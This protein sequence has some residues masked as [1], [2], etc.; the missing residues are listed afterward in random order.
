MRPTRASIDLDA[1]AR[2]YRLL[3]DR[4]GAE[5]GIFCVVKGDA[6]GHGAAPVARRLSR[7]GATRFAV[8]MAEEG[9]ALRRAGI[10]GEI[11]LLNYSDPADAGA[12]RAYGLV[13]SL[14]DLRQAHEF[15]EATRTFSDPLPVHLKLDTGMGRIGFVPEALGALCQLL[16]R[17]SGLR[18]A[19]TFSNLACA[20]DPKSPRTAKQVDVFRDGVAA[21]AAARLD[22]G[23]VHLANSAGILLHRDTWFDAVRPG[24]ALYGVAP[25]KEAGEGG[26]LAPALTLETRVMA[27]SEVA[28][29]TSLGYGGRFVTERASTIAVLPIGYH[30]GFRRSF[31]G[32][33]RVLLRGKEMPVVGAVSMDLTLVDA[34]GAGAQNGDRVVCLGSEGGSRITAWDLARAADTIP[35]EIFCGIGSRVPRVYPQ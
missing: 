27:V 7:E 21:L 13:P 9:I 22:P 20:E 34:S 25:S 16:T 26:T 8:A 3:R 30:D 14:Y 1:I 15:V 23:V 4:V 32:R 12:L 5:R 11:L 31:S 29:G 19:G 24:L 33:V 17:S 35:Y 10:E 28:P 2:N 6:Y 18:V